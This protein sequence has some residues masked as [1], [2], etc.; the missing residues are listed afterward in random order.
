MIYHLASKLLHLEVTPVKSYP[1]LGVD[2]GQRLYSEAKVLLNAD[3]VDTRQA[4]MY[5]TEYLILLCLLACLHI[6]STSTR[7]DTYP[8][9]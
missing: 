4:A 3:S 5:P 9:W 2:R 1:Y 6:A 8:F 7:M